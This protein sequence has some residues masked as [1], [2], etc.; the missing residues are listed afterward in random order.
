MSD[1]QS[2]LE[3]AAILIIFHC[4]TFLALHSFDWYVSGLGFAALGLEATLPIPQLVKLF[5]PFES[6]LSRLI[7]DY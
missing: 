3:F 6:K 4:V 5:L 1:F 7:Y 2:Y